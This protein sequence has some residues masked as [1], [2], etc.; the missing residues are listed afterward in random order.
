MENQ[1]AMCSVT[2]PDPTGGN[3]WNQSN[4]YTHKYTAKQMAFGDVSDATA[5]GRVFRERMPNGS[6]YI[7][8]TQDTGRVLGYATGAGSHEQVWNWF[9]P[10]HRSIVFDSQDPTPSAETPAS[11][12]TATS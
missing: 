4:G 7:V 5:M 8:W 10:I 6:E 3:T 9:N 2:A 1:G 12:T 11:G